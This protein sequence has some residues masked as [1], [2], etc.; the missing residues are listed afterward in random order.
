MEEIARNPR[1]RLHDLCGV[2]LEIPVVLFVGRFA[3]Q[4]RP[5]V[6]VRS[7]AKIFELDPNCK[8]HFAM[9][10]DGHLIKSL[11]DLI[12]EHR[13]S[14]RLHLLGAHPNAAELLADASIL[15]M[16][17]AYEGVALVSYEAMALGVPQIFANVGGQDELITSETG[18]LIENGCGEETRYA[19][20]CLDLLSDPSRSAQM[21]KSGKERMRIHFTAEAAVNDYAE[22]FERFAALGRKQ[23][24]ETP[25]LNPPLL[26]P[27]YLST[28]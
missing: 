3:N 27:L 8:A 10:G 17:S 14:G 1:G 18:I 28:V 20:A 21:A 19:E 2:S 7:V 26:E 4:K 9:V 15:M 23:A 12:S 16:P 13:L 5:E 25:H 24:N 11:K 22:I 6:F